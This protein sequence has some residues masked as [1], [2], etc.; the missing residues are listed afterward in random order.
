MNIQKKKALRIE[1]NIALRL[2]NFARTRVGYI[3]PGFSKQEIE[4]SLKY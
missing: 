4:K 1:Q 2:K 3:L